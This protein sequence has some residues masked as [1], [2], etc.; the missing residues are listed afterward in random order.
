MQGA[1]GRVDIVEQLTPQGYSDGSGVEHA[2]CS[3][4]LP[5]FASHTDREAE[6]FP[7][8]LVPTT[9]HTISDLRLGTVHGG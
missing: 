2:A 6:G 9:P 7:I 1:A 3:S 8:L 5:E 4:I